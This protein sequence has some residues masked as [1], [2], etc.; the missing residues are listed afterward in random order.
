MNIM[1]G[2]TKAVSSDLCV[3]LKV[4]LKHLCEKY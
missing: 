3:M 4:P 1:E 2:M